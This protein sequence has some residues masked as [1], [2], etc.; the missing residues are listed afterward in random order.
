MKENT[1]LELAKDILAFASILNKFGGE[2]ILENQTLFIEVLNEAGFRTQTG[3][4]FTKMGF[5]NMFQRL[6]NRER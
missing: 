4:E 2:S 1:R 3:K 6:T 5:R